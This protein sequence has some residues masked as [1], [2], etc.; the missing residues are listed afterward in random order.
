MSIDHETPDGSAPANPHDALA[1]ERAKVLA[2]IAEVDSDLSQM[3]DP[4]ADADVDFGEEGG[5]GAGASVDRDRSTSIARPAAKSP[6]RA[7]RRWGQ[8]R[9]RY[10]RRLPHLRWAHRRRA[11]SRRC[12]LRPSASTAP[13]RLC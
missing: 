10:L 6:R 12:R 5:E 11:A 7:R 2:A 9:Q 8:G 4:D 3:N 1:A 13:G